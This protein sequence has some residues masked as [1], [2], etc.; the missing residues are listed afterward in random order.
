MKPVHFKYQILFL[1]LWA[2]LVVLLFRL[3]QDRQT[4]A[5]LAGSGFI[6][7]PSYFI[8]FESFRR[9]KRHFIV[10]GIFL[11]FAAWPIFLMRLVYWGQP[12][13]ELTLMGIPMSLLHRGSNFLYLS[14]LISAALG[15]VR[16]EV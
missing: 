16:K 3:I 13:G 8:F 6:F 10:I 11:F 2:G 14:M 5:V 15:L 9:Q 12:F 4:A 1:A 7:I